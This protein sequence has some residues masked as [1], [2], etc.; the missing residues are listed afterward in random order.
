MR[1]SYAKFREVIFWPLLFALSPAVLRKKIATYIQNNSSYYSNAVTSMLKNLSCFLPDAD[2]EA[3]AKNLRLIHLVDHSDTF[4]S[5]FRSQSA[6][7]HI[8]TINAPEFN[9]R[10]LVLSGHRG[11]AWWLL[12]VIHAKGNIA[13]FVSAPLCKPITF[14]EWLF[15][16]YALFRWHQINRIGGA[17]LIPMRGASKAV[18]EIL[19]KDECAIALIDIPP[20]LT[21]LCSPVKFFGRTA[22]MPRR[23]IDIAIEEQADIFYCRG[24]FSPTDLRLYLAFER[25]STK[26]GPQAVFSRYAEL[27]EADIRE[28][29]GSWHAWGHA[30][31]F[32]QPP[33]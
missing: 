13:N 28:R 22:Y 18:K 23:L 33:A 1:K 8:V 30:D 12:P 32:F 14:L 4:T 31:L 16:P 26:S 7:R 20:A 11:N 3:S 6:L 5:F 27:L 17:P 2:L 10:T 24:D 21:P 29:P 19:Q 15:W 9:Q 25:I